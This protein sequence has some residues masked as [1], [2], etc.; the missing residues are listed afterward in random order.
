MSE[1]TPREDSKLSREEPVNLDDTEYDQSERRDTDQDEYARLSKSKYPKIPP[2]RTAEMRQQDLIKRRT[3]GILTG[4]NVMQTDRERHNLNSLAKIRSDGNV[5]DANFASLKR[6]PKQSR[7]FKE[8]LVTGNF[9][10]IEHEIEEQ[11]DKELEYDIDEEDILEYQ[12]FNSIDWWSRRVSAFLNLF[13]GVIVGMFVVNV[14]IIAAVNDEALYS[15]SLYFSQLFTFFVNLCVVFSTAESMIG[16]DKYT[17]L[18]DHNH[19]DTVKFQGYFIVSI[20]KTII[21]MMCWV[22]ILLLPFVV[23]EMAYKDVNKIKDS[24][25]ALYQAWTLIVGAVFTLFFVLTPFTKRDDYVFDSYEILYS[26]DDLYAPEPDAIE[27]TAF[28]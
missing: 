12:L 19:P 16:W 1:R 24:E 11:P 2:L 20:I 13:T 6:Q 22:L 10:Q 27:M 9:K 25:R 4:I 23:L 5:R 26:D 7:I 21:F 8:L 15:I 18:R 14:M 3:G 17:R 28:A